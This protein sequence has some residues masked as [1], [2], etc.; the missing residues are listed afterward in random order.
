MFNIRYALT[1]S[2][3]YFPQTVQ[4]VI[5]ESLAG[6]PNNPYTQLPAVASRKLYNYARNQLT[7]R[8]CV[9]GDSI[10]WGM[11]DEES[12]GWADR[13]KVH[14]LK[15]CDARQSKFLTVFN[16]GNGG[17][18][19]SDLTEHI[20]HELNA[21]LDTDNKF[22]KA[23]IVMIGI[24][25]NDSILLND[26]N[27]FVSLN[28]FKQNIEEII[29]KSKKFAEHIVLVGLIPVVESLTTPIPWN[30]ACYHRNSSVKQYNEILKKVSKAQNVHFIDLYNE[31]EHTDY[32]KL[33]KDGI[34]PNSKGHKKICD[35]VIDFLTKNKLI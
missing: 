33:I 28:Q 19:S 35:A 13:L 14:L 7:M 9:F 12:G 21:W 10:A 24:G 31:W 16:F 30:I 20:E 8:I 29:E 4:L 18:T 26:K 5:S 27:Q 23:N 6:E 1:L 22:K 25:T 11:Q 34:H 2:S 3:E 32:K 15:K 17:E